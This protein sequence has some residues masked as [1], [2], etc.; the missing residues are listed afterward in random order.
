MRVGEWVRF[1]WWGP[2]KDGFQVQEDSGTLVSHRFH[3]LIVA[4]VDKHGN[5]QNPRRYEQI[6]ILEIL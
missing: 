3:K 5:A 1:L 2:T 4:D 6:T